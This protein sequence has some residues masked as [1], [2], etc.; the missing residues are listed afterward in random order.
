[1]IVGEIMRMA[2]EVLFKTHCYSFKGSVFRQSDG[3]P[4]GLRATCAIARVVM[5]RHSILW[6]TAM[7]NNNISTAFNG[8][9][10]DDGRIIMYSIRP[11]WRWTNGEL[12]YSEKWEQEDKFLSPTERTRDVL[13]KTVNGIVECLDFTMETPEDFPDNWLPTLDI[14]MQVDK[15]NQV[16]Y[17]F[18][19]KPTASKLCLQADTALS[20]NYLV[21]S[22]V[23]DVMRRML[24]CSEHVPI[25]TR[26]EIIDNFGQKMLNSGHHIENTR[27]NLISGLKGW[28][29]KVARCKS[30]GQPI[31]RTARQSSGSRRLKKLVGKATWFLEK[32]GDPKEHESVNNQAESLRNKSQKEKWSHPSSHRGDEKKKSPD[33]KA[34]KPAQPRITS[35]INV[36]Q[37]RGGALASVLRK[38]ME[39]L[40]PMLEFRFRVIE[41]AGTSLADILTNKNLWQGSACGRKH[42]HPCQQD[43]EKRED[44]AKENILYKSRCTPCN[45]MEKGK[46]DD[47]IK[48]NRDSASI[49][50]G[51]TSRSLMERAKE[52]HDDYRKN[53]DDSH[54]MKHWAN[55]HPGPVKPKF[56]QY[57]IASFKSSLD[58]QVAEAVRIQHRGQV[59]N[60]V[61]VYN[62]SKLTRLVVDQEWD[63]VVWEESWEKRSRQDRINLALSEEGS[64]LIEEKSSMTRRTRK[65]E[66]EDDQDTSNKRRKC[67]EQGLVWGEQ[68]TPMH[69]AK[70]EFLLGPNN[71]V[72]V[73]NLVQRKIT[74]LSR[75]SLETLVIINNMISKAVQLSEDHK[76]LKLAEEALMNDDEWKYE[77]AEVSSA[78]DDLADLMNILK[79]LD[80]ESRDKNIGKPATKK[81]LSR[82]QQQ[83]QNAA[84]NSKKITEFFSRKKNP[85]V[86]ENEDS[87]MEWEDNMMEWDN[88]P[89]P[90]WSAIMK[91]EKS[92]EQAKMWRRARVQRLALLQSLERKSYTSRS[93]AMDDD[94]S[95]MEWVEEEEPVRLLKRKRE[96]GKKFRKV[97]HEPPVANTKNKRRGKYLLVG[98]TVNKANVDHPRM[99]ILNERIVKAALVIRERSIARAEEQKLKHIKQHQ[100][101]NSTTK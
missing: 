23:Q 78:Q 55:S 91:M 87:R 73:K 28:K 8:V 74:L 59:L 10:V 79:E 88:L 37:T 58:R 15:N 97:Q 36:E 22:L 90:G 72:V 52:H 53:R 34:G 62:R 86:V 5:A 61:G 54:M 27:R 92:R 95:L 49:Y 98:T 24:N 14:S 40:A 65:R 57:V 76:E 93:T 56:H 1:M 48:D 20:Q 13:I 16:Q 6:K 70:T 84:R 66:S 41:S 82:K 7:T 43:S 9:C 75:A 32:K 46:E 44:C 77:E 29:N 17:R 101:L 3:G 45:G 69:K 42:C 11:G 21:Q 85:P 71:K 38:K 4:I 63:K 64:A 19:E 67:E 80:I 35:V 50:V 99:T 83:I 47:N 18:F 100:S 94:Q 68:V 12:W 26:M 51:E 2:V 89:T 96:S 33:Q 25:E 60:S 30:Q 39:N 31:H 81:K